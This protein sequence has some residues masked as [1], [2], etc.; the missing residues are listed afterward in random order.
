[1]QNIC[2]EK[3]TALHTK[4]V[5]YNNGETKKRHYKRLF[6]SMSRGWAVGIA[7]GYGL[8]GRGVGIRLPVGTGIFSSRRPDRFWDPPSPLSNGYR[9]LFPQSQSGQGVKMTIHQLMPRS[10]IRGSIQPLLIN[11]HGVM[12]SQAQG[13]YLSLYIYIKVKLSL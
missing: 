12:F 8:D 10:R 5:S 6:S 7:N 13:L 11:L 1:V 2:P 3:E 9:G 4:F